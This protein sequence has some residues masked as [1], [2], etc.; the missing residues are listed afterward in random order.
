MIINY[1]KKK[2]FENPCRKNKFFP[3]VW[4]GSVEY[5]EIGIKG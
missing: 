1:Q 3:G 5:R 4:E 2:F